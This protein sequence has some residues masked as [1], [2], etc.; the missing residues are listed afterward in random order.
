MT[1]LHVE[2][3]IP[4]M[5]PF[6]ARTD[7]GCADTDPEVFYP[8][9]GQDPT[10]A[11]RLCRHCPV[12][13]ECLDWAI[14]VREFSHGIF[15]EHTARE[16]R[17]IARKRGIVFATQEKAPA[18]DVAYLRLAFRLARRYLT[19]NCEYA[20]LTGEVSKHMLECAVAVLRYDPD[21]E[22]D[23]LDGLPLSRASAQ[24][25]AGRGEVA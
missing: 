25:R 11:K 8:P 6:I 7:L 19:G 9:I 5:P 24:A 4:S 23:V 21:L 15:G 3:V 13:V 22:A 2:P 12:R 10:P 1:R 16:R 18:V 20:D 17:L 14:G